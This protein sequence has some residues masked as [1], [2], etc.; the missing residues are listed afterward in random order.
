MFCA[1]HA[2][3]RISKLNHGRGANIRYPNTGLNFISPFGEDA[4]NPKYRTSY[5]TPTRGWFEGVG[6]EI[7][8]LNTGSGQ[9]VSWYV[10]T[11]GILARV[12]TTGETS[13]VV[14]EIRSNAGIVYAAETAG[15][16][17]GAAP[18][19]TGTGISDGTLTWRS[20]ANEAVLVASTQTY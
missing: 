20:I 1:Q 7:K 13:V 9:P 19:G 15:T 5:E 8:N 12:W 10:K 6:E 16:T 3:L 18:T 2:D 4:I 17:G 14:N 11:P